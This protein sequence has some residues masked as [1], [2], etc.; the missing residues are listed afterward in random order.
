MN[1]DYM[2]KE[3]SR[4]ERKEQKYL[5]QNRTVNAAAWQEAIE[6]RVPT[7]LNETLDA[8]FY[9]AFSL[10]FE[11]G[12]PIIE[13]T[14]NREKLKQDYQINAYAAD[15][16]KNTKT[17]RS[18]GKKAAGSRC[19][20]LAVSAIEGVGMG[21]LGMGI[22]DIPVFISVLLKSI[23]E[24]ALSYGFSY[25]SEEEKLFILKLIEV[26]LS[27]EENLTDGNSQIDRFIENGTLAI[28]KEEQL[29]RT[30]DAL[31]KELLYL[32]FLQGIPVVGVLGGISDAYYQKKISAYAS[33][34]YQ[35][36]F[37]QKR[38]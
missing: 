8:A 7:K 35:R 32:K 30:S 25:D 22:P 23:Y 4:L 5:E 29:H 33:L 14:Y 21:A 3:W 9:K 34:K 17:I 31:S 27:H 16:R 37:L 15:V 36:R 12:T 20:N 6:K 11:K 26:A 18:F 28:T 2:S 1:R 24:I 13:K 10:V 38:S 19:V